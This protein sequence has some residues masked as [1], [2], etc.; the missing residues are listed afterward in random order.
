MIGA[1][2]LMATVASFMGTVWMLST[3]WAQLSRI[4]ELAH[5]EL[6]EPAPRLTAITGVCSCGAEHEGRG[7][8]QIEALADAE[9]NHFLT[10]RCGGSLRPKP[11]RLPPSGYVRVCGICVGA[12]EFAKWDPSWKNDVCTKCGKH[13]TSKME[14]GSPGAVTA[15]IFDER[16]QVLT[17]SGLS[18]E[19][20][21]LRFGSAQR[22]LFAESLLPRVP[23]PLPPADAYIFETVVQ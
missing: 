6:P 8:D 12:T 14:P 9:L 13:Q 23:P 15:E 18:M 17:R 2:W 4:I 16:L 10:T 21:L 19:A 5:A 20:A 3:H 1:I 22:A 11:R 7:A